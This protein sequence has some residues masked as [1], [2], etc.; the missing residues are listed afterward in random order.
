MNECKVSVMTCHDVIKKRHKAN[1]QL[2]GSGYF[3]VKTAMPS[4]F[5]AKKWLHGLKA[6]IKNCFRLPSTKRHRK[7]ERMPKGK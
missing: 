4:P 2:I 7:V 6:K 1:P 5:L 3:E